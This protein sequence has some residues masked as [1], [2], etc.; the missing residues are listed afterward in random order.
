MTAASINTMDN[1]KKLLPPIPFPDEVLQFLYR[2]SLWVEKNKKRKMHINN[3]RKTA[4]KLRPIFCLQ[5]AQQK[6]KLNIPKKLPP[7]TL[8]V[9]HYFSGYNMLC[10]LRNAF[11]HNQLSYDKKTK[12]IEVRNEKF[13]GK[14]SLE[15]IQKFVIA[16]L[17]IKPT[18]NQSNK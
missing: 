2:V 18:Q 11:C 15:T 16:F 10:Q 8:Y 12:L 6:E 9:P 4:K 14:F 1:L 7:N 13:A 5:K 17:E 3:W